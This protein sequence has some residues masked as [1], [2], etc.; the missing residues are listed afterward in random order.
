MSK[1]A[2]AKI[3]D[4]A[5]EFLKTALK[6]SSDLTDNHK[7]GLD[8]YMAKP[9]GNEVEG[10]SQIV[11]SDV[12]D[13]VEWVMPS[14]MKI[15]FGGTR[16]VDIKPQGPEDEEKA[17]LMEEKVNFDFQRGINGY[18]VLH[19]WFKSALLGKYAVTKYW[20]DTSETTKNEDYNGLTEAELEQLMQDE[21]Y[22]ILEEESTLIQEGITDDFGFQVT[23]PVFSFDVKG[24]RTKTVS[25][26]MAKS[27]PPEEFIFDLETSGSIKEAEFCAHRKRVHKNTLKKYKLSDDDISR[28]AEEFSNTEYLKE[29]RFEDLGG[30]NFIKDPSDDEFVYIYECY[31]NDY[32][33]SGDKVPKKVL[34]YGNRVLEVTDNTYGSPPFCGITTVRIPHR[35]AGLSMADLVSDIQKLKTALMRAILDNMYYQN[36]GID[37]V[38]PYR[39]NMDD[40]VDRNEPGAKWRTLYDVDPRTVIHSKDPSPLPSHAFGLL[41]TVDSIKE[42]RTG[43][44]SYNQGLDSKSLNK[45]ATGISQIMGAAQQRMEL[46]ARNFAET[47]V[48]ELFQ[49]FVDM[50][51]EF[52]DGEA[53]VKLNEQWA[54]IKPEMIDGNF[55]IIIDV[56]VGTGSSEI[57]INQ[58]I[59]MINVSQPGVEMGIVTPENFGNLLSTIYELM[60]YKN[61]SKFVSGPQQGGAQNAQTQQMQQQ[62]QQMQQE[63]QKLQQQLQMVTVDLRNQEEKYKIDAQKLQIEA[64]DKQ[65]KSSLEAQKIQNDLSVK[66]AELQLKAEELSLKARELQSKDEVTYAKFEMEREKLLHSIEASRKESQEP[67]EESKEESSANIDQVMKQIDALGQKFDAATKQAESKQKQISITRDKSGQMVG[68]TVKD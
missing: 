7:E 22:E 9:Y 28:E 29:S 62:M 66:R 30:I 58:L 67:R 35:A 65:D 52:F 42:K 15:F 10:R 39:I 46:I 14:L 4:K 6:S 31:L 68:A 50:N 55:D 60:G 3:K 41:E 36:N 59:N 1:R 45:T 48:K 53:N 63:N 43:V 38:N 16:V 2:E 47:G 19:D 56:G 13:T 27:L 26:P 51:L 5:L 44:T 64:A 21:D 37:I 61:T 11:M 24:K 20:W 8:A 34:I 32:D 17:K 12:A 25:K 33:K 18:T 40:V 57:Q 49:A 23:P 54:Q